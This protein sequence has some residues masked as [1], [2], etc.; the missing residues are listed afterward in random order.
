MARLS[1]GVKGTT[2]LMFDSSLGIDFKKNHLILTLLKKSLGKI[3]LVDYGIHPILP[4][5]QKEER[6]AQ[7]INL[8][9]QFI[10]KHSVNREKVSVSI[11]R[12]KVVARFIQLPIAT[13]ENLRRVLEYEAPKYTP[14]GNKEIYFDYHLIK[15]EKEWL[16]LFAVFIKKA[17]VDDYLLLLKK[18]GIQ[19]LSIQIPSTAALNLFFYHK[20]MEKN[21]IAVLLD[22]TE[23]FFEMNLIQGGDW[24]ESFHLPLPLE[25]KESK[26]I[27]T[28]KR[29]GLKGDSSSKSTFFVY[30]LDASEKMLPSLREGNQIKGVF[31]PPL[32]RIEAETGASR[33][34]KIFPSIGVPL[35][36]LTKT[37]FDLNLLPFEMRKRMRQIGKPLFIIL[38]SL[39]LVLT[40]TWG[41]GIFIGYQNELK[42]INA[43]MKKKKPAVEAVEKL[44]RQKEELRKEIS[45]LEKIKSGEISK[46][47]ILR[48]FTQLLPST[49]WIW[50][51]KYTGREIEISGFADSASDL[52]PLLDKSLVFEKVEFLTPVTKERMMMGSE[53]KEK[54]RFKIKMR[55]EARRSGS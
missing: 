39:A 31:L 26:I 1:N 22:V 20:T 49:V 5:D 2:M 29:L 21:E 38:T 25:E 36:G 37:R 53:A 16:Q 9:N 3:K 4:E 52:I 15:E 47:E 18:V 17:E 42:G 46:I 10:S 28:F 51:L 23:P 8:I 50:N 44:Q 45:E 33:P 54:E 32:N 48:E 43:E 12:E 19:P 27:N 40:L 55:L 35:K 34:D 13:K 41:M 24:R 7:V 30:G 11:P 6:E 14:F